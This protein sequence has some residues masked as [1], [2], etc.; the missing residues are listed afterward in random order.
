MTV[1]GCIA[2]AASSNL[3]KRFLLHLT[4]MLFRKTRRNSA[5]PTGPTCPTGSSRRANSFFASLALSA[6]LGQVRQC[7]RGKRGKHQWGFMKPGHQADFAGLP[8]VP[9]SAGASPFS[10]SSP[11]W[12]GQVGQNQSNWL[13]RTSKLG[14]KHIS[15]AVFK[16]EPGQVGHA[17]EIS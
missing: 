10:L 4:H 5:C 13:I 8:P 3:L 16:T 14:K 7:Q 1:V 11:G 2:P 15:V 6:P 9:P 12:V 17:A